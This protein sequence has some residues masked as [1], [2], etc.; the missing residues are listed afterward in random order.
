MYRYDTARTPEL[1]SAPAEALAAESRVPLARTR[2]LPST[3]ALLA[4]SPFR[5]PKLQTS[6]CPEAP[7]RF[8]SIQFCLWKPTAALQAGRSRLLLSPQP[9][10]FLASY[11][12]SDQ[13]ARGRSSS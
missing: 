9:S 4:S 11:I 10:G 8:H 3:L 12:S 13:S 6:R 5:S 7:S 1:S 2:R